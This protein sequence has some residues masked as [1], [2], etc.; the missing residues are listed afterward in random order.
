MKEEEKKTPWVISRDDFDASQ[1]LDFF[2]QAISEAYP[3]QDSSVVDTVAK[4][5]IRYQQGFADVRVYFQY[6][7]D[8]WMNILQQWFTEKEHW[9]HCLFYWGMFMKAYRKTCA[10]DNCTFAF[11]I[12]HRESLLLYVSNLNR[13]KLPNVANEIAALDAT[14][15]L[16]CCAFQSLK[17]ISAIF[18]HDIVVFRMS[19]KAT[20]FTKPICTCTGRLSKC[21]TLFTRA[22]C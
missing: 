9:G 4:L 10:C 7:L 13:M 17:L 11:E 19:P 14:L 3:E 22:F 16:S 1:V 21:P 5:F 8:F 20:S 6:R 2:R 18:T 15:H 12:L